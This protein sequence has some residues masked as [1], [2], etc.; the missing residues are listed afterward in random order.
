MADWL[1]AQGDPRGAFITAQ[2]LLDQTPATDPRWPALWARSERLL[3]RHA[4]AWTADLR[5]RV[6]LRA[7]WSAAPTCWRAGVR[8]R[9]GAIEGL[10]LADP[11]AIAEASSRVPLRQVRLAAPPERFTRPELIIDRPLDSRRGFAFATSPWLAA[12]RG[13][14]LVESRIG[15][16]AARRLAQVPFTALTDLRLRGAGLQDAGA[17]ALGA[18]PWFAGLRRLDLSANGLSTAGLEALAD[19]PRLEA[20]AL[21]SNPKIA[22]RLAALGRLTACTDLTVQSAWH[23]GDLAWI[24]AHLPRLARL[25]ITTPRRTI[26]RPALQRLAAA[27]PPSLTHLSV[28]NTRAGSDLEPLLAALSPATRVLDLRS[29]SLEDDAIAALLRSPVQALTRL[30]L[31]SNRLS[32]AGLCA[33]AEW[34]AL[35]TVTHLNLG[36]NRRVKGPG[37]QALID[38]PAFDPVVIDLHGLVGR[39]PLLDPLRARFGAALRCAHAQPGGASVG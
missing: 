21:T 31:N 38:A 32:D 34:P 19:H 6:D 5:R 14:Q 4:P 12:L 8:F 2:I 23:Q 18:A 33:L 22:G 10:S 25:N 16:R 9:R 37:L 35:R 1:T 7:G 15:V 3:A 13:L 36:N 29:D 26:R 11:A 39:G 17:L 28:S 27:L 30:D 20:L 24:C